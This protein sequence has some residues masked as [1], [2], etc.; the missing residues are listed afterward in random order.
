MLTNGVAQ[1]PAFHLSD[2]E[3]SAI[4]AY[5]REMDGT[6]IGQARA[7]RWVPLLFGMARRRVADAAELNSS[8]CHQVAGCIHLMRT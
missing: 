5:L 4:Q 3:I 6:G 2:T 7:P 8:R 1:M